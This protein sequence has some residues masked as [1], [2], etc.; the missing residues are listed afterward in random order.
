KN[1]EYREFRAENSK[2]NKN[3]IEK[4]KTNNTGAPLYSIKE[5][6]INENTIE[7][8]QIENNEF[9]ITIQ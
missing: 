6:P 9:R 2:D 1:F 4:N 8:T 5:N 7:K 3:T